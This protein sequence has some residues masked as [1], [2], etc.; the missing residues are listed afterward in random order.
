[1]LEICCPGGAHNCY[2][3][4]VC[5][6]SFQGCK[7]CLKCILVKFIYQKNVKFVLMVV[8]DNK[9]IKQNIKNKG[10]DK[11]EMLI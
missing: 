1:M 9:K 6:G 10:C 5:I 7:S 11:N 4:R 3:C 2:T 8:L